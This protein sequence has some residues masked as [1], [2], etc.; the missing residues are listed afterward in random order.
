LRLRIRRVS[1]IES[2]Q[3]IKDEPKTSVKTSERYLQGKSRRK[4]NDQPK[5]RQRQVQDKTKTTNIR[6]KTEKDDGKKNEPVFFLVLLIPV[7]LDVL[8]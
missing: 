8:I 6:T 4:V 5:A 7:Y 2:A 3:P 1:T